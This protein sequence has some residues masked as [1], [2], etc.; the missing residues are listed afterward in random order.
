MIAL[1]KHSDRTRERRWHCAGA[2]FVAATAL[3]AAS[4]LTGHTT[5]ALVAL[6]LATVGIIATKPLFWA[7]PTAYLSGPA[8]AGGVALISALW[9]WSVASLVRLRLAG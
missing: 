7:M 3:I 1:S 9:G 6:S 8:M 4:L 5:P 2:A